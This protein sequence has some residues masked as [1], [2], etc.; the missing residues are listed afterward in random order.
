MLRLPPADLPAPEALSA[1]GS[2]DAAPLADLVGE[3]LARCLYSRTWQLREAALAGLAQDLEAG[4]MQGLDGSSGAPRGAGSC[5]Q[6]PVGLACCMIYCTCRGFNTDGVR[7]LRE[8]LPSCAAADALKTLTRCLLRTLKDKVAAVFSASLVALRA[9]VAAQA[10]SCAPRDLQA[11]VGE[12]LPLL[13]EK[14]ADLNQ[15]TREQATETLV[16]LAGVPQAGLRAACGPFLRPT[17]PNAAWKIVVGR[18]V[19]GNASWPGHA[20]GSSSSCCC[21]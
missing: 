10:G 8:S 21:S 15:R 18:C 9:L 11:A 16:A 2:K 7:E 5:C 20:W 3:Y 6:L 1:G 14:A 17:K 19:H 12:L 13:V 4:S